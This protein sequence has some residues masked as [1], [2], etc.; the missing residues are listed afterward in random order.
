MPQ[1]D[2]PHQYLPTVIL[3]QHNNWT[4]DNHLL[5]Y[6]N[7]TATPQLR[8]DNPQRINS[9][10]L[11]QSGLHVD[12]KLSRLEVCHSLVTGTTV[13]CVQHQPSGLASVKASPQLMSWQ[14]WPHHSTCKFCLLPTNHPMP[15]TL[16][17]SQISLCTIFFGSLIKYFSPCHYG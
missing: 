4:V 16:Q 11:N 7:F 1:G 17:R 2:N 15:P 3:S 14:P 12:R 10:E 9:S 5:N 13:P 8:T 6:W